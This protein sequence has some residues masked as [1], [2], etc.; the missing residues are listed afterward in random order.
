MNVFLTGSATSPPCNT[1][2]LLNIFPVGSNVKLYNLCST[3]IKVFSCLLLSTD[4]CR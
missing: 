2:L 4:V 3:K 1:F